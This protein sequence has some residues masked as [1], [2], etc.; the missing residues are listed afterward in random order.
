ML[1][2][3]VATVALHRGCGGR[4]RDE[5]GEGERDAEAGGVDGAV[6]ARPEHPDLRRRGHLR[7]GPQPLERL[8]ERLLP[9]DERHQV[10]HL[11]GVV[12]DAEG[13]A[14]GQG[15][16]GQAVA[17]RCAAHPEIDPA[18]VHQFQHAEVLGHLE[19]RIVRQHHAAGTD[20]DA[21]GLPRHA[22]DEDLGGRTRERFGRVVLGDPVAV[23]AER[24][25]ALRERDGVLDGGECVLA[26]A[27]G[28]LVQHRELHDAYATRKP[29]AARTRRRQGVGGGG[30]QCWC[31]A[32]GGAPRFFRKA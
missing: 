4:R 28:R 2:G 6:E 30:R 31:A 25:A 23:V 29:R 10:L 11:G 8:G 22:R 18:R 1:R 9:G 32:R 5:V 12:L 16:R 20:P 14:V 24:L 21:L 3:E 26:A 19:R 27:D 13:V 15:R 17:A 7:R